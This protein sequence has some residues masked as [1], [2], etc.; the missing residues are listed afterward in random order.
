MG[1]PRATLLAYVSLC[2]LICFSQSQRPLTGTSEADVMNRRNEFATSIVANLHKARDCTHI[3]LSFHYTL[4]GFGLYN[5]VGMTTLSNNTIV[6]PQNVLTQF[7]GLSCYST[8]LTHQ[9]NAGRWFFPNGTQIPA[10]VGKVLFIAHRIGRVE[11]LINENSQFTSELEG[12]Y[13]CLI[14]DETNTIH[15]LYAG[16]YTMSSYQNSGKDTNIKYASTINC[17]NVCV[18]TCLY[19]QLVLFWI[20]K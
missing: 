14:P 4:A 20:H 13:T 19:T 7:S 2:N 1:V 5:E 17:L 11:L 8:V 16:I 15:T 9:N 12:V 6:T 10:A 18:Y 3:L